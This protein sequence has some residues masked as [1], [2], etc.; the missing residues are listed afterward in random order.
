M[1]AFRE[2]IGQA[3][4]R[5]ETSQR[6]KNKQKNGLETELENW[7]NVLMFVVKNLAAALSESWLIPIG[8]HE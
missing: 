8:L 5:S 7:T 4:K 6:L 3:K 2:E 1:K